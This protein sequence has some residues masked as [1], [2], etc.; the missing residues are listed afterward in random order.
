[1]EDRIEILPVSLL[2]SEHSKVD[3]LQR[4]ARSLNLEFG[5]HYLLDLV[6]ILRQIEDVKGKR[7]IDA[8]AGMGI[9]QWYLAEHGSKVTSVDRESRA[10]LPGRFRRRFKVHGLREEDLTPDKGFLGGIKRA[11]LKSFKRLLSE[12][13]DIVR[14]S[15]IQ[16]SNQRDYTGTGQVI[17]YNQDL[18]TL[19]DIPDNSVD[20]IVAV[21][22]LEHN[23]H[24]GLELVVAELMRVLMPGCALYATLGAARD[25]DWFHTPSKGWCYSE[26]TLR[27]IFNI[28]VDIESNYLQYDHL[29]S[30]LRGSKF[31]QENL[32]SFYLHSGENGMPWGKWDPEYQPVGIRKVKQEDRF[33]H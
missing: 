16:R 11:D 18:A 15:S 17:I 20:A 23:S 32:A 2:E 25:G 14:F 21:S 28:S 3:E 9:M 26:R 24:D 19:V 29:F 6:W 5:W 31:L 13:R 33:E 4:L 7:I 8:G 12:L 27:T 10:D 22:S 1:V 30:E